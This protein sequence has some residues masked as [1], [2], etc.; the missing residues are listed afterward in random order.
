MKPE[1]TEKCLL[2]ITILST[3]IQM[4]LNILYITSLLGLTYYHIL[5]LTPLGMCILLCI[6]MYTK[7][8]KIIN[9]YKKEINNLNK[10]LVK[11]KHFME[12][13][14]LNNKNFIATV[15]YI[16]HSLSRT[17]F[18]EVELE[19]VEIQYTITKNTTDDN[20]IDTHI[21]Y[22]FQGKNISDN[23]INSLFINNSADINDMETN[24]TPSAKDCREESNSDY[25]P[26]YKYD[27]DF[28]VFTWTLPFDKT[29]VEKNN[30]FKY[31]FCLDW[32]YFSLKSDL[33]QIIIDP[34]N[35]STNTKSIKIT[36]INNTDVHIDF[37]QVYQFTRNPFDK[38]DPIILNK[39]NENTWEQA[40]SLDNKEDFIYALDF[41]Q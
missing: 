18:N 17:K 2:I 38:Q 41:I 29:G 3:F 30:P 19:S 37:I 35:Y 21:R 36:L 10:E 15:K 13:I 7:H 22:Y 5:S 28:Q 33:T 11:T 1:N 24:I 20:Y 25:T 4:F 12:N 39:I 40:F 32:K 34:K 8:N 16:I 14:T 23:T 27:K 6:Y 26:N 9:H 31:E